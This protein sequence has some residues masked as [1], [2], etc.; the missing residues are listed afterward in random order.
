MA[1]TVVKAAQH[2]P[3]NTTRSQQ[4]PISVDNTTDVI[5]PKTP[6]LRAIEP[7][8]CPPALSLAEDEVEQARYEI[9]PHRRAIMEGKIS[10][11]PS[12]L[13][14]TARYVT[15]CW[16]AYFQELAI[17]R[18]DSGEYREVSVQS[19]LEGR[20]EKD[21]ESRDQ[22]NKNGDNG[23]G[24]KTEEDVRIDG[25]DKGC[26]LVCCIR[27]EEKDNGVEETDGRWERDMEMVHGWRYSDRTMWLI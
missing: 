17:L 5:Y 3:S 21:K 20:H 1:T 19:F 12:E 4:T 22:R 16:R 6:V 2:S 8:S 27:N 7:I 25:D 13:E 10:F 15:E 24:D 26:N 11:E 14:S 9:T 18:L 23:Q